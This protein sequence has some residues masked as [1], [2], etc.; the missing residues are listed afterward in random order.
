MRNAHKIIVRRPEERILPLVFYLTTL[1]LSQKVIY[2]GLKIG[3][4]VVIC[5]RLENH[6][7]EKVHV[8]LVSCFSCE[9]P[10]NK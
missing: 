9:V 6:C 4:Q 7:A 8:G 5:K 1:L 10:K 2:R 3:P